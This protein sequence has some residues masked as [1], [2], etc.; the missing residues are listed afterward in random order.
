MASM[1]YQKDRSIVVTNDAGEIL[2]VP[3][4]KQDVQ[5]AAVQAHIGEQ[6]PAK[7]SLDEQVKAL[8]VLLVEKGVAT[9]EEVKNAT[10]IDTAAVAAEKA[11][12][13]IKKG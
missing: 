3:P 6:E 12:T 10:S 5:D 1:I 9:D 11:D 8:S 13:P 2:I 4:G 7:L